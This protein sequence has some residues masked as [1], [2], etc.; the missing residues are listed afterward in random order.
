MVSSGS[1]VTDAIMRGVTSLRVGSVPKARMALICSETTMEPSSEAMP[2]PMR[3][4]TIRAART[5]PNSRIRVSETSCPVMLTAP[6][7]RRALSDWIPNTAP[8]KNPV[9]TI[10]VSEPTPIR[11]IWRTMS[12]K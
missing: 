8:V 5:G 4:A 7:L 9:S 2:E 11:S 6:Y 3:P 12:R 10:M 1:M